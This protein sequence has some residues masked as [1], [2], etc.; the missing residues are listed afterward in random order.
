MLDY[1]RDAY[2]GG[3]VYRDGDAV[4]DAE[5]EAYYF[6]PPAEW[7]AAERDAVASLDGP[8]LDAGCGAGK[9]ALRLQE[10]CETV[11]F[12]VSPN[13]VRAAR[14]RGVEHA[15]TADMFRPGFRAD[16]FGSV[17][18]WGAQVGL[19]GSLD[20][21]ADLL[22]GFARVTREGADLLL[23]HHDPDADGAEELFG[24][25]SDPRPGLARRTFRVEYDRD[26]DPEV[27]PALEFLL[28]S[29]ARLREAVAATPWRVASVERVGSGGAT[30]A[31]R[32][33]TA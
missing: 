12:D 23:S 18:L 30:Y 26:G 27:G 24:Y 29:P 33:T 25:R 8:A 3:C 7:P 28:F 21:V 5:I 17:L 10:R 20:G 32:L 4:V 31:A 14:E 19:G 11:A 2:D 15:V 6:A 13:A 1:A 16:R 22:S 9:D